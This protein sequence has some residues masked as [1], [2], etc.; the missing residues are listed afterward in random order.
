MEINFVIEG[1]QENPTGNP[2]P[3]H[4][5]TQGSYWNAGNRRYH[6]WKDYVV[7]CFEKATGGS[8]NTLG[9]PTDREAI[10]ELIRTG[11]PP[12][13]INLEKKCARMDIRIEWAN[14]AHAD[15]DNIFKGILDALFVNDK[16]VTAGS[17]ESKKSAD[18]VGKVFIKIIIG[19]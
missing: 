6:A 7:Q 17:F 2:I 19:I 5:A 11:R 18:G 14:G 1:N 10:D 3:Y 15:G 9:R 12:K 8:I 13:P 4:R 16:G